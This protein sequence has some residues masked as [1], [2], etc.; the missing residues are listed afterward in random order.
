VIAPHDSTLLAP[1]LV[2]ELVDDTVS[3]AELLIQMLQLASSVADKQ[4]TGEALIC[5]TQVQEDENSDDP[6]TH[7]MLSE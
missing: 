6:D 5:C 2:T 3:G 7:S 1:K 4:D